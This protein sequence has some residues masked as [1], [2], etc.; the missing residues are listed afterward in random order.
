MDLVVERI[1]SFREHLLTCDGREASQKSLSLAE[2]DGPTCNFQKPLHSRQKSHFKEHAK[3]MTNLSFDLFQRMLRH[4]AKFR[5]F[6]R[7]NIA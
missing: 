4:H 6:L 7:M 1:A 5:Q 2:P 3:T